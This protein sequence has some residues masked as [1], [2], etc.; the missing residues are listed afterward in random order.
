[1][2]RSRNSWARRHSELRR[3]RPAERLRVEPTDC[4]APLGGSGGPG[5][6]AHRTINAI[7]FQSVNERRLS[8]CVVALCGDH[9]LRHAVAALTTSGH[10]VSRRRHPGAPSPRPNE[11]AS[12][13][14][15]SGFARRLAGR[16][17]LPRPDDVNS[18]T[19]PDLR[20]RPHWHA[21][22]HPTPPPLTHM[23]PAAKV[24]L[25]TAL[26]AAGDMLRCAPAPPVGGTGKRGRRA[27][28]DETPITKT[29]LELRRQDTYEHGCFKQFALANKSC[30]GINVGWHLQKLHNYLS[31]C[32]ILCCRWQNWPR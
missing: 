17:T 28:E 14:R 31:E 8:I 13:P 24:A 21:P 2:R 30:Y 10:A 23:P 5:R 26:L 11:K 16:R 18:F 15:G 27:R 32:V 12:A 6:R 29:R 25:S 7:T 1:M 20:G 22:A 3:G 4:R 19:R 9:T